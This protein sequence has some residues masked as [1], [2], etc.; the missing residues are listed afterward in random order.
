MLWLF[1]IYSESSY[2]LEVTNVTA[3][4]LAIY[5]SAPSFQRKEN[6]MENPTLSR[7]TLLTAG[8]A[9]LAG[10][11]LLNAHFAHASP[12]Q[13]GEEVIPWLDQPPESPIPPQTLA[14]QL[15]WEQVD[16]WITPNAKFFSIAH[17]N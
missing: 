15:V 13:A 7:R 9:T 4:C 10:L 8:S 12:L 11:A 5:A 6:F 16:S 17:Y 2:R 3:R 1:R 14:T